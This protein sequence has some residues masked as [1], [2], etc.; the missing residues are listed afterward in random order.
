MHTHT[1]THTHAWHTNNVNHSCY[2]LQT[3]HRALSFSL[4]LYAM[5]IWMHY[6]S[7]RNGA[8]KRNARICCGSIVRRAHSISVNR[9]LL[10][11]SVCVDATTTRYPLQPTHTRALLQFYT[12]PK[13]KTQSAQPATLKIAATTPL[14]IRIVSLLLCVWCV[15]VC[16]VRYLHLLIALRGN[17]TLRN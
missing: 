13:L 5:C 14:Q 12:K 16:P 11:V 6:K 15:F 8:Y 4:S 10:W 1:H 7:T 3:A 17:P 2:A 9:I